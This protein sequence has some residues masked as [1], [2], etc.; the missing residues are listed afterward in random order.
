VKLSSVVI[1]G[2]RGFSETLTLDLSADVILVHGPNGTGKTSL[3]DAVLWAI[4]G[5]VARLGAPQAVISKYAEFGEAR[6]ELEL[7]GP[8][9]TRLLVRRRQ[10]VG[11]DVS[12]LTVETDEGRTSGPGAEA[13]LMGFLWA[14]GIA[15]ADPVGSLDRSITRAVYLQQDDVT[16]FIA[17]DD[18]KDRFAV[19]GEIVGAGRIGELVAAL[20]RERRA[21]TT[22]T[23][24]DRDELLGPLQARREQLV[25]QV[26]AASDRSEGVEQLRDTWREWLDA[27]G[28]MVPADAT[29]AG[30]LPTGQIVTDVLDRISQ[31]ARGSELRQARLEG[32]S[33]L[34]ESVPPP[35]PGLTEAR[36]KLDHAQATV[37]RREADVANARDAEADAREQLVRAAEATDE[38]AALAQLALRHVDGACPV[39]GQQHDVSITRERLD[40]LI[41]HA[42]APPIEPDV[43][44]G[45]AMDALRAATAERDEAAA[46]L[47]TIEQAERSRTASLEAIASEAAALDLDVGAP[48]EMA[49]RIDALLS[50]SQAVLAH[51]HDLRRTGERIAAGIARLAEADR[52]SELAAAL[53]ELEAEIAEVSAQLDLRGAVGD[54]ARRLHESLRELSE[55]LVV[56]ELEK[57]E[58]LLRRIYA[59]VDPH[60]SFKVVKLLAEMRRG[61]GHMWTELDDSLGDVPGAVPGHVL[62]SSQL[63]VLAV[64]TFMAMNLSADTLPL[65]L[66]A[67][68][69]PLQSLDN[70][71]LLGLADLLRRT[72]ARRQL[73]V[74]THD[75][76]LAGLLERK[77]RPVGDTQ[78]TIV[79]TFEGWDRAGPRVQTREVAPDVAPLRLVHRAG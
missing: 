30:R 22:K 51:V 28:S 52:A 61:R 38:L 63:N 1:S 66:A 50:E 74:S 37:A 56:S 67:L 77:L 55:S 71:N 16:S 24:R 9:G 46:A 35:A 73:M 69:D 5:R 44:L 57:I 8:D 20:E 39:C 40:D 11:Q 13:A 53:P 23:N 43:G 48:G 60:P 15:S 45:P 59:S 29:T 26:S 19:V 4:T 27:A 33:R 42:Q 68:D 65:N 76:R 31:Q 79:I 36:L 3:F 32:L 21:W 58:P 41:T 70:V 78:R 34:L 62:S 12:T 2:F 25:A 6:I 47:K 18:E 10:P 54:D 75:D 7:L 49:A 64:V 72:R 14:D 17:D